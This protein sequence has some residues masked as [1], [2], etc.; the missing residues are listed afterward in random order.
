MWGMRVERL[1]GG[2]SDVYTC[3]NNYLNNSKTQVGKGCE[4]FAYT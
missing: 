1:Y 3:Y 2:T 4:F